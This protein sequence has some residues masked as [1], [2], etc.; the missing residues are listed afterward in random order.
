M[1]MDLLEQCSRI[2]ALVANLRPMDLPRGISARAREIFGGLLELNPLRK[3]NLSPLVNTMRNFFAGVVNAISAL[4]RGECIYKS[5]DTGLVALTFGIGVPPSW[6]ITGN[7]LVAFECMSSSAGQ[8]FQNAIAR[9][10]DGVGGSS[11]GGGGA[12]GGS[13]VPSG[14]PVPNPGP[15]GLQPSAPS[16]SESLLTP[17]IPQSPQV[18]SRNVNW[19]P[20]M[21]APGTWSKCSHGF[22][23]NGISRGGDTLD[24]FRGVT[25]LS[26]GG[27]LSCAEVD[28]SS[29]MSADGWTNCPSGSAFSGLLRGACNGL[30]CLEQALCCTPKHGL[31][32]CTTKRIPKSSLEV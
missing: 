21:A 13:G 26:R 10:F 6:G 2:P 12:P 23:V 8:A 30:S 25:C 11:G 17:A 9:I 5:V 19:A 1:V 29:T 24:K 22:F 27:A 31:G 20:T 28:I 16:P 7:I 15:S 4:S 3:L 14:S 32:S 18:T